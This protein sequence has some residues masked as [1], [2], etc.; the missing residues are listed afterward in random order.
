MILGLS[1]LVLTCDDLDAACASFVTLG[2]EVEFIERDLHNPQQKA[3][4]ITDYCPTHAMA[5]LRGNT[6][7][8]VELIQHPGSVRSG[9]GA[10][11][12]CF[13][14]GSEL[15]LIGVPD[16]RRWMLGEMLGRAGFQEIGAFPMDLQTCSIPDSVRLA[17]MRPIPVPAALVLETGSFEAT[18]AFWSK[19]IGA[20]LRATG[21]S[22]CGDLRWARLE[23]RSPLPS[24]AASVLLVER[25]DDDHQQGL[26]R[27]DALG[28]TC[29][30]FM[31]NRLDNDANRLEEWGA[32]TVGESFS[33]QV[34]RRN[35]MVRLLCGPAGEP[36][37]LF[38]LDG[39]G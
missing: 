19:G 5:F 31:C 9:S 32:R 17:G 27:L 28:F 37:E 34:N 4:L 7:P 8:A 26:H 38:S 15:Q 16:E 3:E 10:Y 24:L 11:G 25:L 12:V 33:L 2:F 14:M 22:D 30:A 39:N 36:I 21:D 20:A 1:H 6:G 23:V 29:A 13:R 35:L 18:L